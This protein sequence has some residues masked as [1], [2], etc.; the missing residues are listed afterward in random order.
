VSVISCVGRW[1][2]IDDIKASVSFQL[3]LFLA[4]AFVFFPP[5]IASPHNLIKVVIPVK[6][7]KPNRQAVFGRSAPLKT[8]KS[9]I[10]FYGFY[11]I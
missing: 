9:V 7:V 10:R 3:N 11:R 6:P 8:G 2:H 4:D 5:E 1:V